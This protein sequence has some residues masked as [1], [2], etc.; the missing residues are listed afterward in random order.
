MPKA[1]RKRLVKE[2]REHEKAAK[3]AKVAAAEAFLRNAGISEREREPGNRE[4][5]SRKSKKERRRDR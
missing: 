2:F 3:R 4:K 5:K 1:E